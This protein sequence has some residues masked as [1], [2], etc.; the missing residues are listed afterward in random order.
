MDRELLRTLA[1]KAINYI[2]AQNTRKGK[3]PLPLTNRR[4]LF[5]VA[6]DEITDEELYKMYDGKQIDADKLY[7]KF[8][9]IIKHE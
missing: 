6:L 7:A 9:T 8:M 4:S 3:Y 2:N 1:N 5:N